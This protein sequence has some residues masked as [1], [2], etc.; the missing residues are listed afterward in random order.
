MR[1]NDL[2]PDCFV[3]LG[4]NNEA[5]VS[6]VKQAFRRLAKKTHPDVGGDAEEFKLI[7]GAYEQA[8]EFVKQ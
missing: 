4:L 3:I 1:R 7:M 8:L 2:I 6:D 5:T